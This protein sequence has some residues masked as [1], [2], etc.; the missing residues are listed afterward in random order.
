MNRSRYG[1]FFHPKESTTMSH[2]I[3][4]ND[5]VLCVG[6]TAWH[7]LAI[8]LPEAFSLER[9]ERE[10]AFHFGVQLAESAFRSPVT[11]DWVG[12]GD[13]RYTVKLEQDGTVSPFGRVGK[14]FEVF[15]QEQSLAVAREIEQR[16]GGGL[17]WDTAGTLFNGARC[18]LQAEI[19]GQ[20]FEIASKLGAKFGHVARFTFMWGHDGRTPVIFKGNQTCV[21][22]WNTSEVSLDEK[23]GEIRLSHTSGLEKRI[24]EAVRYIT[25][26]PG[27]L[28]EN[29]RVLETLAEVPM[30]LEDFE[31]F[32]SALI[33]GVDA[34][35][36][37]ERRVLIE[38]ELRKRRPIVE[39][40]EAKTTRALT[41]FE[42][43]LDAYR[44]EFLRRADT[45][46]AGRTLFAAESAITALVDHPSSIQ[47][48]IAERKASYT[49]SVKRIQKLSRAA[50]EAMFG[51]GAAVKRRAR[52]ML[53]RSGGIVQK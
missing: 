41:L 14:D 1:A 51:S 19:A 27:S 47:E 33:L 29:R 3:T 2:G 5:L 7:G 22:C 23:T 15:S 36:R 37:E 42:N 18:W 13:D 12:A 31:E 16:L 24:Q 25:E 4:R 50:D 53:L 17:V 40:G 28:E 10:P 48:W 39:G 45:D 49:E 34:D 26:L 35:S 11:G 9:L 21:V 38:R 8:N 46:G 43:A 20:R 44:A 52:Q 6:T 32:A 30:G